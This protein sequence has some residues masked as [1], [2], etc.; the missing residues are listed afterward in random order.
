MSCIPL[1]TP[2]ARLNRAALVATRLKWG[3]LLAK[4]LQHGSSRCTILIPWEIDTIKN[5]GLQ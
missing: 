3:M 4:Q 1:P 5:S 2:T